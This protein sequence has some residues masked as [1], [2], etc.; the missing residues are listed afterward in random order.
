MK[1]TTEEKIR[2]LLWSIA[3]ISIGLALIAPIWVLTGLIILVLG[4]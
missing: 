4:E 1:D 2:D 3:G